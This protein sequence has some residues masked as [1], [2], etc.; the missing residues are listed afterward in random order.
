MPKQ[1]LNPT[2]AL[3]Q[4]LGLDCIIFITND[5]LISILWNS[6]LLCLVSEFCFWLRLLKTWW[7]VL[8][9]HAWNN[10]RWSQTPGNHGILRNREDAVKMFTLNVSAVSGTGI[11]LG[12]GR[13]FPQS[14]V[15]GVISRQLVPWL[16]CPPWNVFILICWTHV[17][18]FS[19]S[20][21]EEIQ[22]L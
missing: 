10:F 16:S 18:F 8:K 21:L 22:I 6:V 1:Y 20:G 2:A 7:Y 13:G 3:C 12:W 15:L 14:S 11:G 5:E 4:P 17:K 19:G 9:L